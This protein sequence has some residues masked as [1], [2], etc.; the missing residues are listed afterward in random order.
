MVQ[1]TADAGTISVPMSSILDALESVLSEDERAKLFEQLIGLRPTTVAPGDLITA[2]LFN[3]ILSDLND[4]SIR[5]SVLEGA[6]GA[7]IVDLLDPPKAVAVNTIL[8]VTGRNFNPEP[9]FNVVSIGNIEIT[10]FRDDSTPTDLI[11]MVPDMFVGLPSD[12]AVRVRNGD[13]ISNA[14]AIKVTPPDQTQKGAYVIQNTLAPASVGDQ[15]TLNF[16]WNVQAMTSFP[17]QVTLEVLIGEV[18]GTGITADSWR[19]TAVFQPLSPLSIQPGQTKAVSLTIKVPKNATSAQLAFRVTSQD[20]HVSNASDP[21]ELT[22]GGNVDPNSP[23]TAI[24]FIAPTLGGGGMKANEPIEIDGITLPG[25]LVKLGGDGKLI[26]DATDTRPVDAADPNPAAADYS[27]AAEF[28]GAGTGFT[29]GTPLPLSKA[30]VPFHQD[31]NF[32][33]KLKPAA[34]ATAGM[35][36]KLKVTCSQTKTSGK[37]VPYKTFRIIHLKIVS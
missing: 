16:T 28:V 19:S 17:D 32:D 14:V 3:Q 15:A 29:L 4:L 26:F 22:V 11:F 13:R 18:K 27:F 35:T 10:Q 9:R 25:V 2:E 30:G 21:I 7:P 1:T 5:L 36:A 24:S 33:L 6:A 8:K 23:N 31:V 34:G 12:L 20:G 37:L